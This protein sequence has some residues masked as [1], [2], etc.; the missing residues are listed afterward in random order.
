MLNRQ[1]KR[2]G[3]VSVLARFAADGEDAGQQAEATRF[4]SVTCT[5]DVIQLGLRSD[6]R[7]ISTLG[8]AETGG[9]QTI[10]CNQV[11]RG[12]SKPLVRESTNRKHTPKKGRR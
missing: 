1:A 6:I 7:P 5:T 9:A 11:K 12:P 4:T 10:S 8:S 2:V 3:A